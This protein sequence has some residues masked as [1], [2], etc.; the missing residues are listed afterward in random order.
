MQNV[1][2][3]ITRPARSLPVARWS[4]AAAATALVLL[5]ALHILSPELDP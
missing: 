3:T 1:I 4:I 5:V 2:P